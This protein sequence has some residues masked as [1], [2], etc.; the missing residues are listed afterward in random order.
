MNIFLY[1]YIIIFCLS[2]VEFIFPKYHAVNRQVFHVA[3][4]LSFIIFAIKYYFG[5][6]ILTY[7]PLYDN[8]GTPAQVLRGETFS[9]YEIEMG[10]ALFCS[11]LKY[12]GASFW[13]MTLVV[14][15]FYFFTLYFV[16][17]HIKQYKTFAL[18]ILFI[19]DSNLVIYEFRQCISVSL[20]LWMVMFL[21]D[22]KYIASLMMFV[23]ASLMHKSGLFIGLGTFLIYGLRHIK[24]S[25]QAY[26]MLF[27]LLL[28]FLIIPLKDFLLNILEVLPLK[29]SVNNSI[30][31]HLEVAKPFQWIFIIYA[32]TILCAG[33]YRNTSKEDA[34]WHW[35]I[36]ACL[37]IVVIL[38]QY[39]FI[40]NR[41]RSYFLPLAIV[42]IINTI[43]KSPHKSV[44]PKQLLVLSI[45]L[46]SANFCRGYYNG[47][48][49]SVSKV[50]ATCTVFDLRKKSK[51][52]IKKE[53]MTKAEKFWKEEY[54]K[55]EL[56]K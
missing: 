22:K 40:L 35:I 55:Y 41:L 14:T 36:F 31:H 10:Y 4:G 19:L 53:Q 56:E 33:Y 13:M 45:L 23:L 6:D 3:F 54:L 26:I 18:L 8:I 1:L 20:Y 44:L 2:L 5:P 51:E 34:K 47:L 12:L 27:L 50:N 25:K 43:Q 11:I 37:L 32:I 17:N 48:Q 7:V 39:W 29:D 42:Y 16:L 9:S 21:F 38:F 24:I 46:F 30:E 15:T 49:Q 52:Q 28:T